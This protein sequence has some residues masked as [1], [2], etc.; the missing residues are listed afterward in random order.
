MF[1][2][3]ILII[4]NITFEVLFDSLIELFY[5]SIGLEM[6]SY[7]KLVVYFEFCYKCYKES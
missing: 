5:L 2:L 6:K 1:N 4:V 3:I 7:G